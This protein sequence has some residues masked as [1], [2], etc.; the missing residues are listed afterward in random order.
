MTAPANEGL[1][2]PMAM[3]ICASATP[4]LVLLHTARDL[5]GEMRVAVLP[6]GPRSVPIVYA[7]M[8][9]ALA[10]LHRMEAL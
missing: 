6:P 5:D 9:A 10:A 7:D 8:A 3:P 1:S 2:G 4:R